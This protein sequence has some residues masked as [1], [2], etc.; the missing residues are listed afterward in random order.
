M[1]VYIEST[2]WAD[3]DTVVRIYTVGYYHPVTGQWN[4]ESDHRTRE[5]AAARVNYLNGGYNRE[6]RFTSER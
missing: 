6:G 2:G 5:Q 3:D 4:A 1:W